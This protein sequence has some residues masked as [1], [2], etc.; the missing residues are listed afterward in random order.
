MIISG[1]YKVR[2]NLISFPGPSYRG[3]GSRGPPPGNCC[4][5]LIKHFQCIFQHFK[6]LVGCAHPAHLQERR[7]EEKG[8]GR[9]EKGRDDDD[10]SNEKIAK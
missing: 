7:R 5:K 9:Q 2:S 1:V 6:G 8:E 10:D 4:E 3:R